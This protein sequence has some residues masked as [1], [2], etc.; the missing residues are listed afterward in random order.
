[1]AEQELRPS[2]RKDDPEARSG[3]LNSNPLRPKFQLPKKDEVKDPGLLAWITGLLDLRPV[4]DSELL[5]IREQLEGGRKAISSKYF[6]KP[7]PTMSDTLWQQNRKLLHHVNLMQPV[8][9]AYVN[10]V[11]SN[12]VVRTAEEN[13]YKEWVQEW[14]E[15]DDLAQTMEDWAGNK[16]AFGRSVA[17]A[18]YD[19]EADEGSCGFPIPFIRESSSIQ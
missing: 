3:T 7:S 1:M 2:Q 8:Q 15:S 12:E 4:V 19:S 5:E 14:L 11:Y 10:S 16:V 17:V 9:N 13:P 18:G 6:P